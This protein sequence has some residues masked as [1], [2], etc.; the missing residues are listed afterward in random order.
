MDTDFFTPLPLIIDPTT[1]AVS[2]NDPDPAHALTDALNRLNSTHRA[3]QQIDPP[4]LLA[5]PPPQPPFVNPKRSQQI[6]KL[7]EAAQTALKK[8]SNAP[9][10]EPVDGSAPQSEAI[11][12]YGLALDMALQRPTWEP[13]QLVREELAAIYT[14]RA[15]AFA[16]IRGWAD[17]HTDCRLSLECK[18]QG[19]PGAWRVGCESLK[20]M[21]RATEAGEWVRM[22][23]MEESVMLN[24]FRG[25]VAQMQQGNAGLAQAKNALQGFEKELETLKEMGRGLGVVQ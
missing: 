25:Q 15:A 2:T 11:K 12:L 20:E 8:Q 14:S 23:V 21:G 7:R 22:A 16:A 4:N 9:V 24:Q 18:R 19:N 5:P 6:H 3:L 1:K 13:Q 10:P 17:A